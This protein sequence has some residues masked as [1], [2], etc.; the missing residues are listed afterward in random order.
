MPW[1]ASDTVFGTVPAIITILISCCLLY[2]QIGLPS[3]LAHR[4]TRPALKVCS[5]NESCFELAFC[6]CCA[7]R[8]VTGRQE[9]KVALK[10]S[11]APT[12]IQA[13]RRIHNLGKVLGYLDPAM[14]WGSHRLLHP[15]VASVAQSQAWTSTASELCNQDR[16]CKPTYHPGYALQSSSQNRS[17]R[18]I[19]AQIAMLSSGQRQHAKVDAHPQRGDQHSTAPKADAFAA[20]IAVGDR[21]LHSVQCNRYLAETLE[22]APNAAGLKNALAEDGNWM[23]LRWTRDSTPITTAKLQK[24]SLSKG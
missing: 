20:H 13:S 8:P 1:L 11:V 15:T 5:Q 14:G 18:Q 10:R 3:H 9:S 21:Q 24:K 17:R 4:S 6:S 12:S 23:P 16:Q 7:H 2:S 22:G 19:P